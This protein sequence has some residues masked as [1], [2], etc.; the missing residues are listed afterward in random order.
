MMALSLIIAVVLEQRSWRRH[1]TEEKDEF[2]AGQQ[3]PVPTTL[4]LR[5]VS[6]TTIPDLM[7]IPLR[8]F[9]AVFTTSRSGSRR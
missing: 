1:D 4:S 7:S 8:T 9:Y 6:T 2:A 5:S 3:L